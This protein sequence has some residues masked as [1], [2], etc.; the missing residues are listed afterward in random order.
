[1]GR[2]RPTVPP[3]PADAGPARRV[4]QYVHVSARCTGRSRRSDGA[5]RLWRRRLRR[6]R[7]HR[8][9]DVSRGK[10][11][12]CLAACDSGCASGDDRAGRDPM[13]GR[14]VQLLT[15]PTGPRSRMRPACPHVRPRRGEAVTRYAQFQSAHEALGHAHSA[16]AARFA[17]RPGRTVPAVV[18]ASGRRPLSRAEVV[19][20]KYSEAGNISSRLPGARCSGPGEAAVLASSCPRQDMPVALR[21]KTI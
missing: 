18:H 15:V 19:P 4:L 7:G 11:R 2:R 20:S 3:R 1:M 10:L 16:L 14:S 5:H 13:L 12:R 8:Q 9:Y 6:P 21:F 17:V